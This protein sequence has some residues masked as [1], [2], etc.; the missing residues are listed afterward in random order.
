MKGNNPVGL[1][2]DYKATNGSGIYHGIGIPAKFGI[3][4]GVNDKVT[5]K[6][7]SKSPPPRKMN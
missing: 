6:K 1:P 5:I 4:P 7:I 3:K 2:Y